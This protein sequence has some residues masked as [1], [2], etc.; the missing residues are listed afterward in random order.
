MLLLDVLENFFECNVI[1]AR[2][3]RGPAQSADVQKQRRCVDFRA[4]D[5]IV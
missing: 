2:G 4:N 5:V 3:L 1:G